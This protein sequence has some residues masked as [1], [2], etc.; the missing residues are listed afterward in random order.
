MGKSLRRALETSDAVRI[1]ADI[2]L[3]V[4]TTELITP[5]TAEWMLS[6][7]KCNR[8][9]NWNRVD[10][11]SDVMKRGEW[12][13]HS[14]GLIFDPDGFLLTGQT[15]LWAVVY[16]GV[17]VHMRVSRGSPR[18]TARLIDRG[19]P[20]SARDIASRST[21]RKHSPMESSIAR[22]ICAAMGDYRPSTDMLA[23]TIASYSDKMQEL[24]WKTRGT[25]KTKSVLMVLGALC[26]QGSIGNV[27]KIEEWAKRLE[28]A[29]LPASPNKCW[30]RG[31]AF[32]LS[33]QRAIEIIQS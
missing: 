15:R 7:N 14:Q 21:E 26:F 13:L 22:A 25:K 30:S 16:S 29:L 20:Q 28:M 32:G 33:I 23:D 12:K 31:A 24:L 9:V 3:I 10:E 8:P 6:K 17:S 18:E 1:G 4:D 11:Y 2:P 5:Q 19:R 27:N